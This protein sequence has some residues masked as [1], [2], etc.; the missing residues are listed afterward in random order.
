[1]DIDKKSLSERD[2]ISKF[3]LPSI[4]NAG[5]SLESQVREEVTFTDDRILDIQDRF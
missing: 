4:T 5:W 2:F 1:M 3:I